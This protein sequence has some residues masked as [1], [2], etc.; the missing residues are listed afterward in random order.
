MNLKRSRLSNSLTPIVLVFATLLLPYKSQPQT[1]EK[2]ATDLLQELGFDGYQTPQE[3]PMKFCPMIKKSC[4]KPADQIKAYDTWIVQGWKNDLTQ[5]FSEYSQVYR[6]FLDESMKVHSVAKNVSAA[7]N[8]KPKSN[9]QAYAKQFIQFDVASVSK[10]LPELT[11]GFYD[12]L[13]LA[14]NGLF[15]SVCDFQN[16][17][18][19]KTE[20]KKKYIVEHEFVHEFMK[21]GLQ[22][23]VYYH[24]H[25][26]NIANLELKVLN[27]CLDDKFM[28][29][30]LAPSLM[31]PTADSPNIKECLRARNSPKW[32]EKCEKVTSNFNFIQI[33][34]YMYPLLEKYEKLTQTLI[35]LRTQ[36]EKKYAIKSE[37]TDP[38]I[39]RMLA[40]NGATTL[41]D[42]GTANNAPAQNATAT[43]KKEPRDP[44]V[45]KIKSQTLKLGSFG[46]DVAEQGLNFF[47]YG[48]RT[49]WNENYYAELKKLSKENQGQITV[50]QIKKIEGAAAG[51][52]SKT[53]TVGKSAGYLRVAL[54]SITALYLALFG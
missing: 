39:S 11:K 40:D 52:A 45:F 18:Y 28:A 7:L 26:E 5:R 4:C 41:Q 42:N 21:K 36:L 30:N 13:A 49:D 38:K 24:S 37:A 14:Y 53:T 12:H 23:L 25:M 35:G 2:C 19:F 16:Q 20:G 27:Y 29:A 43:R 10:K 15:C 9:C 50:S 17:K 32:L 51:M 46:F 1:A 6:S 44:M 31:L 33:N 47:K 54:A 8:N 22:H 34:E 48:N 3:Y